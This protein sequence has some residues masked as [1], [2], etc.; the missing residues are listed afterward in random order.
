MYIG[1]ISYSL[2]LWHWT[3][4]SIS[5]WTTGVQGWWILP[6]LI[7]T[8]MLATC[9]YE[10][11]EKRFRAR[12]PTSSQRVFKLGGAT[13]AGLGTGIHM[14]TLGYPNLF[15]NHV[16]DIRQH[17]AFAEPNGKDFESSCVVD[18]KIRHFSAQMLADC[19][20]LPNQV[21]KPT[22]WAFGD[23]HAGHLSG[24][25]A[26]LKQYQGLGYHLI[27][28]PGDP[29]PPLS[30]NDR[31]ALGQTSWKTLRQTTS[32]HALQQIK[33]GDTVVLA[34]LYVNRATK[35]A[36]PDVDHW[37]KEANLFSINMRKKGVGVV[38]MRPTPIYSE[39]SAACNSSVFAN[40]NPGCTMRMNDY[41]Q[42][43]QEINDKLTGLAKH[44]ANV[45]LADPT[46]ALCDT[47]GCPRSLDGDSLYRD[48]DHLNVFGS[49]TLA[50]LLTST[51]NVR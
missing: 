15:L 43:F 2:Y 3:V 5:R 19:T 37:I 18:G 30:R 25:L 1:L 17:N 20:T 10:F 38:V 28:T 32:A 31:A 47:Q 33:E 27:A 14:L 36:K 42:T 51:L 22:I 23:S 7:A 9:S 16:Y 34:R 50:K 13:I 4:L 11:I 46:M 21:E 45:S 26:A 49:A 48:A 24:M 39:D 41:R 12:P 44:H 8:L 40:I 35:R 6:Q 29:S